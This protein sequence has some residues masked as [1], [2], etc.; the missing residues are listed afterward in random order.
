MIILYLLSYFFLFSQ[1]LIIFFTF[2]FIHVDLDHSFWQKV[3]RYIEWVIYLIISL[4]TNFYKVKN[5]YIYDDINNLRSLP[6]PGLNTVE[7]RI[8]YLIFLKFIQEAKIEF[9]P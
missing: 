7:L 3:P 6:L 8:N 1:H 4:L 9:T 2:F 5:F